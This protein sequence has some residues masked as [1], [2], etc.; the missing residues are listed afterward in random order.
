MRDDRSALVLLQ[1]GD[2]V[3]DIEDVKRHL[4]VDFD[5]DDDYIE[6]LVS[7]AQAFVDGATGVLGR[8]LLIQQWKFNRAG[9]YD[10]GGRRYPG[11]IAIPLPPLRSIDAI[12][13]L[14][15]S[16]ALQTVSSA[17][18]RVVDGGGAMSSVIP[19]SGI[20]WPCTACAPDAVRISFTAGYADADGLFAARPGIRHAMLLMIGDWYAARETFVTGTVSQEIKMSTAVDALLAPHRV[21]WL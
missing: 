5:D 6:S 16:G 11:E 7:A 8:A 12:E 19:V 17:L 21:R 14:D 13:Y 15:E 9:F 3:L 10:C 1:S 2:P 4:R 20:A 18:Y